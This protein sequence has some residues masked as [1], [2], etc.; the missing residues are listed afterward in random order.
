VGDGSSGEAL[1]ISK[2]GARFDVMNWL[3]RMDPRRSWLSFLW[4]AGLGFTILFV[5]LDPSPS[6]GLDFDA[7]LAF[8]ALH[9]LI[10]LALAQAS[11]LALTAISLSFANIWASLAMAGI[12]A[13]AIFAPVALALDIAFSAAGGLAQS[14]SFN[15]A[16]ILDEWVNLAPPVMLVWI[17]LNAARFLRLPAVASPFEA[18]QPENPEPPKFMERIPVAR[19]GQLIAI[20]AELH[21]LRVYTTMGEAL[22]LQGFGEALSQ[23]SSKVG[24]KIH[25]SHWIDPGFVTGFSRDGARMEVTLSTGLVL[26]VAR[27]RRDVVTTTLEGIAKR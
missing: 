11:Q 25:R 17:G 10:P 18:V 7:R 12:A 16:E 9:I 2:I 4:A 19:R 21:Y 15:M 27:S 1:H 13:S 20:S 22:I 6:R 8:W 14:E 5:M 23:L 3:E 26:P 24:L